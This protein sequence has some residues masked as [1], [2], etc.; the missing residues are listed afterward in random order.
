[1]IYIISIYDYL[2]IIYI[3]KKIYQLSPFC[4][5]HKISI[6]FISLYNFNVFKVH[7]HIFLFEKTIFIFTSLFDY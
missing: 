1:M 2:L 4:R 3:V 5:V 7:Y 6:Y